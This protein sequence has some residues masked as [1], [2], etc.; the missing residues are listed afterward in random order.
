VRKSSARFFIGFTT[1]L[2]VIGL[3]LGVAAWLFMD[4][5]MPGWPDGASPE[6]F[7]KLVVSWGEWGVV[8]SIILMVL[9]SFVPF[10]AEFVA[11]A[12]GMCY[13]L[14]WGTVI[15]WVGAMLGALLAFSLSRRF[16]RPFV[17]RLVAHNNWNEID[18]W[19]AR[20]GGSGV[21]LCRFIPVIAFNLINYAA[22][23]TKISYWTF[24]WT[25]G[26][27]IL[28]MT[29][30]MVLLG[31]EVHELSIYSWLLVAAAGLVVWL[32]VNRIIIKRA[33]FAGPFVERR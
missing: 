14:I 15:T 22:G 12:N 6:S 16:G 2:V 30:L 8:A 9:H 17:E 3:M 5:P 13:G 32:M 26:L 11:I 21:F 4:T 18:D 27:G 25:T 28:P 10:P 7:K 29:T 1:G 33:E 31:S 23:L 24:S 20:Y 19:I